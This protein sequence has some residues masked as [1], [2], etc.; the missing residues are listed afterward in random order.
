MGKN[1]ILVFCAHP[2]DQIFGPGGTLAKYANKGKKIHTFIFSYGEGSHPHFKKEIITDTR[3]KE[4]ERADKI[5]GGNG[6]EFF[7]LPDDKNFEEEY[8]KQNIHQRLKDIIL[9]CE[10]VKIFTHSEDDHHVHHKIVNKAVLKAVD[11]SKFKT[12]VYTF[13]VWNFFGVKRNTSPK[14]VV[15]ISDTFKTKIKALKIFKSQLSFFSYTI[16]NNF[17]YLKVYFNDFIEGL[18]Y[19]KRFAEVFYKVR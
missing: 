8:E 13:D 1:T 15:D 7:G 10:P 18:I 3:V 5:I 6:V 9:K 12:D 19:K 16:M 17:L 14:L 11:E 2:D 4:A